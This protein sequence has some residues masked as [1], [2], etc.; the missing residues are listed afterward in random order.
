MNQA[1][2]PYFPNRTLEATKGQRR[3]QRHKDKVT[4]YLL[5]LEAE[6]EAGP[7]R[8]LTQNQ[9]EGQQ[10]DNIETLKTAIMDEISNQDPLTGPEYHKDRLNQIY[11]SVPTWPLEIIAKQLEIYVL[12]VFPPSQK[13]KRPNLTKQGMKLS[14]PKGKPVGANTRKHKELGKRTRV[15]AYESS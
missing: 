7:L 13:R 14:K 9:D 8:I 12:E 1:L 6:A 15:T 3:A 11:N 2:A 10:S 5:E 4:Q